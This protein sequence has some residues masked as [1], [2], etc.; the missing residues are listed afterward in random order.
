MKVQSC[1]IT[2]Y[3]LKMYLVK[4]QITKVLYL[5]CISYI[6]TS[7]SS[8][9]LK[10][11]SLLFR[12]LFFSI[13]YLNI[14]YLNFA[15]SSLTNSTTATYVYFVHGSYCIPPRLLLFLRF[16]PFVSCKRVLVWVDF[17][18]YPNQRRVSY[19]VQTGKPSL[20]LISYKLSLL[21]DREMTKW[22]FELIGCTFN[23]STNFLQLYWYLLFYFIFPVQNQGSI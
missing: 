21:V 18:L 22:S 6:S 14:G 8:F 12:I 5:Y 10:I 9:L 16:H 3:S 4:T 20:T 11:Y 2:K 17:F 15:W 7:E 1:N 19:V 13:K 23:F